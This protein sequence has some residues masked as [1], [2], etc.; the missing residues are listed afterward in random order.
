MG[1]VSLIMDVGKDKPYSDFS[2]EEREPGFMKQGLCNCSMAI[3]RCWG[4]ASRG[5]KAL[6]PWKS[7]SSL[8]HPS[9]T[10]VPA[11]PHPEDWLLPREGLACVVWTLGS[12]DH[13][14]HLS[15]WVVGQF[16]KPGQTG[17]LDTLLEALA[18]TCPCSLAS[19][20]RFPAQIH[21]HTYINLQ[22][23]S[24]SWFGNHSLLTRQYFQKNLL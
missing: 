4:Q 12:G 6:L 24:S 19:S 1:E 10:V 23:S 20:P 21:T 8:S 2:R 5:S 13:R 22:P 17:N 16:G 9:P 18:W 3:T 14:I 11:M 15:Q 7:T